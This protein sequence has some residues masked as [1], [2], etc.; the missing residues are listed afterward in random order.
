MGWS[1]DNSLWLSSRGG[2]VLL[3]KSQGVTEDFSAT[4]LQ[5]RGFGILDVGFQTSN[6]GY[7]CGG[8][9][10]LYKTL[11][12]GKTWTRDK[13]ADDLAGN[14][15]AVKFIDRDIGFVLGD[16]AILLRFIGSKRS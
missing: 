12:S 4:K 16:D 8:S 10:S 6:I 2:E 13:P 7:A 5:S 14:L 15:Y 1:P 3:G 11:D 9:G